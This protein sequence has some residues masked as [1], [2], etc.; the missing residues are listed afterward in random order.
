MKVYRNKPLRVFK[1]TQGLPGVTL[2]TVAISSQ[3]LQGL[4]RLLL[5]LSYV[6]LFCEQARLNRPPPPPKNTYINSIITR[7]LTH[8]SPDHHFS[9]NNNKFMFIIISNKNQLTRE[10]QSR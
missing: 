6:L 3:L 8:L 2:W 1:T 4:L 5:T 9:K 7:A 10:F